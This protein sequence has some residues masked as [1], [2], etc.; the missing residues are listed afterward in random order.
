MLLLPIDLLS[1]WVQIPRYSKGMP[2]EFSVSLRLQALSRLIGTIAPSK[3]AIIFNRKCLEIS[4]D[5][6]G[7][8]PA[9]WRLNNP[10]D[11]RMCNPIIN[12]KIV[13][14]LR[15]SKVSII[16]SMRSVNSSGEIELVNGQNLQDVDTIILCTG[17]NYDFSAIPESLNPM[18][19]SNPL[20]EASATTS[21]RKLVH[22]YQ[23]IFSLDYPESLAYIGVSGFP[24]SQMPLNDLISMALAQLWKGAVPMPSKEEMEREVDGRHKWLLEM[25]MG[26]DGPTVLPGR[27]NAGSWLQWLHEVAGTGVNENLGYGWRGWLYWLKEFRF[28]KGLMSGVNSPHIWRLYEGRRKRWDG[29]REALLTVNAEARRRQEEASDSVKKVR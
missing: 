15:A 2:V 18:R 14:L 13:D 26:K 6:F 27:M 12:D 20:W 17:Y 23:G 24:A 22:L 9:E 11:G 1:N 25:A 19:H 28:C 5:S 7:T 4:H 21:G 16:Q 8:L 29:A 10:P 3:W